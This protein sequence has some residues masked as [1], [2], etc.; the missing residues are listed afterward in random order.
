[1]IFVSSDNGKNSILEIQKASFLNQE[2]KK[3]SSLNPQSN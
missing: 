1:M 2:K 3:N